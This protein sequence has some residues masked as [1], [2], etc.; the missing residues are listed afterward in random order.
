[1]VE[2]AKDANMAECGACR[3]IISIDSAACPKCGVSFG[4]VSDEPLGACG[5]CGGLAPLDATK[6]PHCGVSFVAD[7]VIEVLGNW[8]TATGL[9]VRALFE[10]FDENKDGVIN[11]F[12]FKKGLI[13]L[14]IA[15]LPPSQIDRLIEALDED[16]D[17]TIDLDELE[18]TFSGSE[19]TKT[20]AA[21][22]TDDAEAESE[23]KDDNESTD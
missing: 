18:N 16:N 7:N 23:A 17:G 15:D 13:A 21:A 12:E 22:T 4:G 5:A 10:R 6:C 2:E 1:M 9:G 14:N 11:A 19:P 20:V 8:L 3:E